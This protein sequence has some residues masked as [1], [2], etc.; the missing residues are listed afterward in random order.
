M[1]RIQRLEM[2]NSSLRCVLITFS[3]D[4]RKVLDS[5]SNVQHENDKLHAEID[6]LISKSSDGA[7]L[8]KIHERLTQTELRLG[9]ANEE[10]KVMKGNKDDQTT[11]LLAAISREAQL[12]T[13][14]ELLKSTNTKSSTDDLSRALEQCQTLTDEN[15]KLNEILHRARTLTGCG[16]TDV[17][18]ALNDYMNNL[19]SKQQALQAQQQILT[20]DK[21]VMDLERS[22]M[23]SAVHELGIRIAKDCAMPKSMGRPPMTPKS[24]T[25][26]PGASWA[27]HQRDSLQPTKLFV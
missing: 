23:S 20:D 19:R 21:A 11:Q 6:Q 27:S 15:S 25:R 12:R 4:N 10:L 9:T 7:E 26:S 17:I 13:E 8:A 5:Y 1:D 14:L 24:A 2:D 18:L 3:H 16:D 22:M